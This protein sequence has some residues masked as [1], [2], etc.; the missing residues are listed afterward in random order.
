MDE[1]E[2]YDESLFH[3]L[4]DTSTKADMMSNAPIN[5]LEFKFV[6]TTPDATKLFIDINR[7]MMM[8]NLTPEELQFV[9]M[10]SALIRDLGYIEQNSGLGNKELK[11]LFMH[12]RE[13]VLVSSL[14]RD[15]FLRENLI[16]QIR[17]FRLQRKE[18]EKEKGYRLRFGGDNADK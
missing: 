6:M 2:Q 15:G 11:E 7:D 8:A 10:K 5:D 4:S 13:V 18:K 9:R 14:S 16:S 3:S 1:Q 17:N 12:D